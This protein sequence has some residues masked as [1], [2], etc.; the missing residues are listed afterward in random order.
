MYAKLGYDPGRDFAPI[1]VIATSPLLLVVHPSSPVNSV[2][3]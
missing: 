2:L 1:T 3:N